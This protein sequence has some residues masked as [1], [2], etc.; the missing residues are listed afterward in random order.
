MEPGHHDTVSLCMCGFLPECKMYACVQ[1]V[2]LVIH[3][4]SVFVG[5]GVPVRTTCLWLGGLRAVVDN[6]LVFIDVHLRAG[7]LLLLQT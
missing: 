7:M 2:L 1:H 4:V 5:V 6:L 3:C